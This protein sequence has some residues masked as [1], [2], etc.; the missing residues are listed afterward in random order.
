MR[1]STKSCCGW[2]PVAETLVMKGGHGLPYS[3]GLMA[4]SLSASGLAP[5][6]AFE[7]ARVVERRLAER[8]ESHIEVG[9]LADLAAE[10]LAADVGE[11]A[12]RRFRDWRRLSRLD[13]PLIILLAGTAGV[14]KSTLATMLASRLGITRVIATDAIR[15]VIRA[16]FST[17]FMP[18]V[19]YSSFEAALAIDRDE[20]GDTDPDIAGFV[21]QATNVRTGVRAIVD[22]ACQERTPM[23]LEGVHLVPGLIR[24]EPPERCVT[25][26][27]VLAVE[28]EELHRAHFTMRGSDRPAQRYLDRF[29]KIRKLQSYL[30]ERAR[31]SG[32]PV[33]DNASI[34][35]AL[36]Q[37][38]E[39]VLDAVGRAQPAER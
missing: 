36:A 25:V 2:C 28:D 23:V 18:V 8:G 26:H 30:V 1:T 38:M 24:P 39:L 21:R 32:V 29:E 35:A 10:V 16:F 4:Q 37:S 34:D 17:D 11:D 20:G 5:E 15:Q 9:D 6:R 31:A 19:H 14:G 27:A 7:L 33:I 22:R 3:K 12:V 13:R